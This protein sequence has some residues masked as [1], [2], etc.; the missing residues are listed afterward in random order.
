MR[1]HSF[2]G[3]FL[4]FVTFLSPTYTIQSENI[5]FVWTCFHFSGSKVDEVARQ[6][7][8]LHQVLRG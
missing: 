7:P 3:K 8:G 2:K 1:I 4:S 5:P 6:S